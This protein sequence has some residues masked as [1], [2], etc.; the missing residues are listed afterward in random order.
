MLV[1]GVVHYK[2]ND[3]AYAALLATA[4]E[5]DEVADGSISRINRVEIA[6]VV[7]IV[8]AG[9][10]LEGHEPKSGDSHAVKVIEPPEKALEV[11]H[12]VTIRIHVGGGGKTIE[13]CVLV[14]QIVDHCA[15]CPRKTAGEYRWDAGFELV[16]A[17]CRLSDLSAIFS[18]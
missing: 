6:D 18:G 5:L 8:A 7:A 1:G 13:D 16:E 12:S 17:R 10:A 15:C 11:T 4:R 2:V 9:G 3:D 14:P